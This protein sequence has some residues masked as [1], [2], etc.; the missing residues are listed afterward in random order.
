MNDAMCALQNSGTWDLVSLP[1][2]KSV[3]HCQ[4]IY[5]FKVDPNGAID[6]LKARLIAK[7]YTQI[8]GLDYGDTFSP[9]AKMASI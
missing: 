4:W 1:P 5:T 6:R 7:G 2:G 9:V 3:V 8:F